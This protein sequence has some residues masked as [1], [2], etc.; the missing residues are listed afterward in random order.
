MR[1]VRGSGKIL[2]P[3][4]SSPSH[5]K[6]ALTPGG[7]KACVHCGALSS[8]GVPVEVR[9]WSHVNKDGPIPAN[10][11]ELGPCWIWS[12]KE[13]WYGYGKYFLGGKLRRAH[14]VACELAGKQIP[15]GLVADHLCRVRACVNPDH[16]EAVTQSENL[17]RSPLT[18]A[19][20]TRCGRGHDL[21]L[22]DSWYYYSGG[23]RRCRLCIPIVS[24]EW[25]T[26]A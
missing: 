18:P 12:S 22:T 8:R 3:T 15:E 1:F 26:K 21:T 7:W 24:K 10:R 20:R 23:R 25:R 5:H 11:P 17:K 19:G 6:M 4:S 9:F 13:L 16:I 2:C 14:L